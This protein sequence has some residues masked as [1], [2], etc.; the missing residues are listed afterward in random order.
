MRTDSIDDWRMRWQ[1]L[2]SRFGFGCATVEL[3]G[4]VVLQTFSDQS[5]LFFSQFNG[6]IVAIYYR[7]HHTTPSW[8]RR[9]VDQNRFR[10]VVISRRGDGFPRMQDHEDTFR[11]ALERCRYWI[12]FIETMYGGCPMMGQN[13]LDK[14]VLR[15][16]VSIQL[17]FRINT[18]LSTGSAV[19]NGCVR[20]R[21]S[22]L[23]KIRGLTRDLSHHGTS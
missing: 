11:D 13:K 15:Q 19:S 23:A 7:H 10:L 12:Q 17:L 6:N 16:E 14:R 1:H 4:N 3:P 5:L 21:M 2:Y 9:R 18:F 22:M 20:H 8:S